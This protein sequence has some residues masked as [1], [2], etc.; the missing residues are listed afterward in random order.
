MWHVVCIGIDI[1]IY[2]D[3]G[4]GEK[5]WWRGYG[6]TQLREALD[7]LVRFYKKLT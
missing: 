1:G 6:M 7:G 5:P 3:V 2:E 4:D